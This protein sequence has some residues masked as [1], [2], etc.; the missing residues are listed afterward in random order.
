MAEPRWYPTAT[1]MPDGKVLVFAGDRIVQNRPGRAARLRRCLRQ[2]AAG[3]LQPGH[4]HLD[5]PDRA[6]QLTS[7]LYPRMFVLSDGRVIDVGPD[8]TTR[9]LTPGSWTWSTVATSPFDGH[10][11][12]MYRPNKIMKSGTWADPDFGGP[13]RLRHE[14]PHRRP[15]HERADA[16]VAR[17]RAD[18]ARARVPQPDAASRRDGARERRRLALGRRR[19]VEVGPARP[20]SGTR[21]PRRGRR[22]TRCTNG[23]QYHST[24]LLLPDGRV[25]MAGGGAVGG[26]HRRSRTPR[27]TR[28]R[29]S[30]RAPGPTI[31]TL[32][33]DD[34]VRRRA[35]T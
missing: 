16:R 31:T 12:V 2:L 14:R 7:P 27:S 19:P 21:T 8:T 9:I 34:V 30:S 6:A 26:A 22:S 11:A 29:T 33:G 24:A 28:R 17:D 20:R 23:R 10:S 25:L 32:A 5:E 3:A 4:E 1:Q 18:G 35:S 13:P 15:R